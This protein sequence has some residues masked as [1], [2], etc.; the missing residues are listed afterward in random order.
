MQDRL[1]L[2]ACVLFPPLV[3]GVLLSTAEAG[4]YTP[5]WSQRILDEWHIAAVRKQGAGVED[6]ILAIQARMAQTFP[7]SSIAPSADIG[8]ELPDPADMHVLAAAIG[9]KAPRIVTF[10]LRDFPRRALWPHGVEAVHP[11]SFLW[12]LFSED[13]ARMTPAVRQ[14]LDAQDV[15]EDRHRAALKRARLPRFGKAWQA[16]Q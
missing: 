7:E 5:V 4:L 11:D 13:V 6:G 15:G 9:A 10:N 1:V 14:A 16:A 3:R 12:Q 2:D 8:L